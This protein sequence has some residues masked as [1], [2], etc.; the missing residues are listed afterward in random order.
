MLVSLPAN[1]FLERIIP[2]CYNIFIFG[3]L[4]QAKAIGKKERIKIE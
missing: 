3:N 2:L 1:F 4:N